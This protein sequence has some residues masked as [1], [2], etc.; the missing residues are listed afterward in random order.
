MTAGRA[1]AAMALADQVHRHAAHA[2]PV[3]GDRTQ[4]RLG[5]SHHLQIVE[6]ADA[7]PVGNRQIAPHRLEQHAKGK[8]VIV[9]KNR[10]S[11]GVAG[12]QIGQK[13]TAEADRRRFGRRHHAVRPV[14][15]GQR[16]PIAFGPSRAIGTGVGGGQRDD[17]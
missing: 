3:G 11:L 17:F 7:Q 6:T 4:R 5:G 9:A 15:T 8:I 2:M 16:A 12:Q 13:P 1:G 10:V 14:P